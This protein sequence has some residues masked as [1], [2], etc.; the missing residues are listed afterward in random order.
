M[1]IVDKILF[2]LP[3]LTGAGHKE[4]TNATLLCVGRGP[5][6]YVRSVFQFLPISG[7]GGVPPRVDRFR[8]AKNVQ[9]GSA[10]ATTSAAAAPDVGVNSAPAAATRPADLCTQLPTLPAPCAMPHTYC[11]TLQT[12]SRIC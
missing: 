11:I 8:Y 12:H 7:C 1:Q 3:Y 2:S 6:R 5:L 10:G 9:I 4:S